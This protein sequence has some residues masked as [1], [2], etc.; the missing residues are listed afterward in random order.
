M[1]RMQIQFTQDQIDKLK[2]L[3]FA[4]RTS[5]SELVRQALDHWFEA[6]FDSSLEEKKKKALEA[7]GLYSSGHTNVSEQHDKYLMNDFL[8]RE[9]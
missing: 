6:Q 8:S 4:K 5:C 7:L 9:P 3:A 2:S 1:L